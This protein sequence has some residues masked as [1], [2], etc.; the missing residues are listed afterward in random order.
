MTDKEKLL[1]YNL[2]EAIKEAKN[3]PYFD[4][5][6]GAA[7]AGIA[8]NA[9][10][11]IEQCEK[12]LGDY[13]DT[14]SIKLF[15]NGELY[16]PSETPFCLIFEDDASRKAFIRQLQ[17]IPDKQGYRYAAFHL[18]NTDG[19]SFINTVKEKLNNG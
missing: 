5:M 17:N 11:K 8:L 7:Q 13:L 10:R 9:E 19:A 12:E 4:G 6:S 18:N 3:L 2:Q 15:V 16:T 1:R 14:V